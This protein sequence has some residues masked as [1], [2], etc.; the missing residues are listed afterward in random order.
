MLKFLCAQAGAAAMLNGIHTTPPPGPPP[1]TAPAAHVRAAPAQAQERYPAL[2]HEILKQFI[3][4]DTTHAKGSSGLAQ[5]IADRAIAAGYAPGDVVVL[6]PA[7]HPT[8]GNV[9]IRLRGKGLGKPLLAN[10]HLD[11]VEAN[12]EDWSVDPFRLTEKDGYFY[13]RGTQDMKGDDALMLTEAIRLKQEGFVPDRDIIFAFTA[14]EE[15]GGDANGMKW[16]LAEHH[17]LVDAGVSINQDGDG[18]ELKAGTLEFFGVETSEKLYV[19]FELETTNRGGHSSVPR[20]DNAIY[21]MTGALG[22]VQAFDFPAKTTPTTRAFFKAYANLQS[23]VTKTDMLKVAEGDLDPAVVKRLSADPLINATL[24]TTCVATVIQGGQ[25]ES[26]LPERVR[27]TVQ[28]RV[29]PGETPEEIR[30]ELA[31]AIDDPGVKLSMDGPIDPSPETT[32]TPEMLDRYKRAVEA[33]WPD[34]LVVPD[35]QVGASDSVYTREA[36]IPSYVASSIA[37]DLDDHRE[38]GRDERIRVS[39]FYRGVAY[40]DQLMKIMSAK[41]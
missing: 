13:G 3:D 11:V 8:K 15:A 34:P 38:H 12:R 19:T 39:A 35:M 10:G 31:K 25:G 1:A 28:C 17:D 37:I 4:T 24:H 26:A 23:G 14:D 9:I 6:A 30:G 32:P 20:P 29:M 40:I 7:D 33:F 16:L 41:D 5:L 27:A 36:G 2:A 22:R 18:A 21:Q